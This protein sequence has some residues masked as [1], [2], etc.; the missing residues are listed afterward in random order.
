MRLSLLIY[1]VVLCT[2]E[3]VEYPN[4]FVPSELEVAK[5]PLYK[6]AAPSDSKETDLCG[7]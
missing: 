2:I 1:S 4:D 3:W 5:L 7:N 6:V